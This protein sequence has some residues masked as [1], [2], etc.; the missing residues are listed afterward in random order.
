MQR[1]RLYGARVA[2]CGYGHQRISGMRLHVGGEHVCTQHVRC[3]I[4]RADR[5]CL[6]VVRPA[7]G[8][9]ELPSL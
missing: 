6:A 7:P 5:M 9:L 2:V 3:A 1:A 8:Q 4:G